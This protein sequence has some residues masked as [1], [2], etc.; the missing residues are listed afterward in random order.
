[1]PPR[2][3]SEQL[4]SLPVDGLILELLKQ[5]KRLLAERNVDLTTAEIK[6]ISE[7]AANYEPLPEKVA[8]I[9]AA[10]VQI[11]QE[12]QTVL[13]ERFGYTFAESLAVDMD[14]ISGWETTAEF[15]E[16]ANHKSNA[17]LRI[18]AGAT[19]L[20]FLGDDRY[21]EPLFAVIAAD[22]DTGDVDAAMARR[23]LTHF[24]KVDATASDWMEQVRAKLAK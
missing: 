20:T 12:S 2:N 23:A 14:S 8:A 21:T 15:L 1:M 18:S 11:V 5:F 22:E 16:I 3:P 7:K 17:E 19:L 4:L 10:M 6:Q 24:T 9:Q 13:S